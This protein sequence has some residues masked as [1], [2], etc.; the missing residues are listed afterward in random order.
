M[1]T[2]IINNKKKKKIGTNM[3]LSSLAGMKYSLE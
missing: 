3:L 1:I 2:F